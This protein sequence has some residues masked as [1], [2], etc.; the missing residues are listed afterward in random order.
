MALD[1]RLVARVCV[2]AALAMGVFA[3]AVA[4]AIAMI[5]AQD[6]PFAGQLGVKPTLLEQVAPR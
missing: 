2:T 4:V 6:R 3:A 5:A 1:G